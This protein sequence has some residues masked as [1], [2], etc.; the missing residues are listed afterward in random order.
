MLKHTV[1]AAALIAAVALAPDASAEAMTHDGFYMSLE[2]GVGY[3]SATIDDPI[4]E[5]T[6]SS[7]TFSSGLLLGG[8][9]G[10]VVIGGGFTYDY[11]F[12]PS[13]E[14]A[15]SEQEIEDL[16]LYLIGIGAFADYYVDPAGGLHFIGFLG[17]GGLESSRDGDA[18]GSDPTG[19]LVTLGGGYDF[20]VADEW[21]IGPLARFTYAPL[22]FDYGGSSLDVPT[23]HF[24]VVAE[25]VY[26]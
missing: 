13:A 1:G 7:T 16:K 6:M 9:V 14:Q 18:G 21:S 4:A 12:S 24:S 23:W 3:L 19:L 17:W 8:T 25:F 10:P 15:G 5:V 11:G 26:H 22:S 2:A 20:W